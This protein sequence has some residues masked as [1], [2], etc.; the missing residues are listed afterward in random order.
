MD[1]SMC[2]KY[3]HFIVKQKVYICLDPPPS[4]PVY[5]LYTQFNVDVYGR[6]RRQNYIQN[7]IRLFS[8][9]DTCD[10]SDDQIPHHPQFVGHVLFQMDS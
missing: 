4:P 2:Q 9:Q 7:E 10:L 8:G 3:Q 1:I 5:V 6:S